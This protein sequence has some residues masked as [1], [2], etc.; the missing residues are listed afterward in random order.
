V[1]SATIAVGKVVQAIPPVRWALRKCWRYD[2]QV[3]EQ[4]LFG[5]TFAN[6]IGLS[7][8]FDKNVQ[9]VPLMSSVGFG[10]ETGGSV[11]LGERKGNARPWFY[12]L[13]RTQSL[14]VHAGLANRG[15]VNS[16][17]TI[18]KNS[19][20]SKGLPLFISVAIVAKTSKETC[21]DAIIDAKNTI[22]YI[23]QHSL[24]KAI[25]INISCPNA[26]DEQPFTNPKMLDELLTELDKIERNLPF[27]IKMPQVSSLKE[28][29]ALLR[30]VDRHNIQGLTIANLVKDRSSVKLL[31][32]L[33]E[34]VKGGLSG[35][36]TRKV[37]TAMVHY[38]YKKYAK[39]FTIIGVGGV[40][41][42]EHAY[43]KIRAG[44]SLVG[45][46]T[47]VIFEGPQVVGKINKG[48]IKLLD[49]DGFT[50]ITEAIGADHKKSPQSVKKVLQN[51]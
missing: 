51:K 27:L 13:P 14:V 7:A 12:R 34:E 10:F 38:A 32:E 35:A 25:E 24:S 33:P 2:N 28:F 43:E 40:F 6:P 8:G 22:L 48:L 16:E 20:R 47:G 23:L 5:M 30:I 29:D 49:E 21:Q 42:A 9:L 17:A 46:I 1:H 36:P 45:M 39:R 15:I 18:I 50:S 44:A 31:E 4:E 26:G 3:L 37:S 19:R 41:S 11:T